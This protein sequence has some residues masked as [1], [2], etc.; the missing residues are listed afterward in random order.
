MRSHRNCVRR[1]QRGRRLL[2]AELF[3]AASSQ[4][5]KRLPALVSAAFIYSQSYSRQQQ[6]ALLAPQ[7][8][9]LAT[10]GRLRN[11]TPLPAAPSENYSPTPC[12]W[13]W[14]VAVLMRQGIPSRPCEPVLRNSFLFAGIRFH[15]ACRFI[16][17]H[18][19]T[20]LRVAALAA[21]A[22]PVISRQSFAPHGV[23]F[24]PVT[25]S[26]DRIWIGLLNISPASRSCTSPPGFGPP[27]RLT[28]LF[29][30]GYAFPLPSSARLMAEVA[31]RLSVSSSHSDNTHR[32]VQPL[33][34]TPAF[35][36][37]PAKG[38]EPSTRCLR[39][40]RSTN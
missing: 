33:A 7:P 30:A 36:L 39:C 13:P 5:R 6:G 12:C 25:K 26:G 22:F 11:R 35:A 18:P 23:L 37:V 38:F 29:D 40:S 31:A 16:S 4:R 10:N 19:A 9:T 14:R 3:T 32:H 1:C 8:V 17:G 34:G 15:P 2:P 28:A 27:V 24:L 21:S 20:L